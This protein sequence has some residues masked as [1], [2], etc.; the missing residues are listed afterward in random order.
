[1]FKFGDRSFLQDDA[2][3]LEKFVLG[4]EVAL[5]ILLVNH[6]VRILNVFEVVL[7]LF[8]R[9]KSLLVELDQLLLAV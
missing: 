8:L 2:C 3:R 6:L 5:D 1:M 4:V 9:N 7:Q